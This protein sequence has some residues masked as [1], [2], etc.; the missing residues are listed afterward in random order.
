M[1]R[2]IWLSEL[3]K[4]YIDS[5]MELISAASGPVWEKFSFSPMLKT[6][7]EKWRGKDPELVQLRAK[8]RKI[9]P[10]SSFPPASESKG[11]RE[12]ASWPATSNFGDIR[13]AEIPYIDKTDIIF[14]LTKRRHV[15]LSRPRRFGKTLL[16]NTL[17]HLYLGSKV[18]FEGSY[19]ESQ[20]D[21][22]KKKYPVI[23]LDFSGGSANRFEES[24]AEQ[25]RTVGLEYGL[26]YPE[27]DSTSWEIVF[28]RLVRTLR[29]LNQS[30]GLDP[31]VVILIDEYDKPVVGFL[32]NKDLARQNLEILNSFLA[33]VKYV[34]PVFSIVTGVSRLARASI[35]SGDNARDDISFDP[36]FNAICG[37]TEEEITSNLTPVLGSLKIE[38][39]KE[40]Y[41]G[42]Y[43]G[44]NEGI[45][46]PFS[47]A[48]SCVNKSI[49]SYW[50][51]SGNPAL[52]GQFCG[53][54]EMQNLVKQ[55]IAS[56]RVDFSLSTL[57]TPY[58]ISELEMYWESL[59]RLFV[60]A[61]YLT[62]N[63][64]ANSSEMCSLTI[65]N[66]E[67]KDYGF[68][69]LLITTLMNHSPKICHTLF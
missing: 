23:H 48:K 24:L 20:W 6:D 59:P 56:G 12:F 33:F 58:D 22:K 31:N 7:L 45:Y 38:E 36:E 37:F 44:G 34:D 55:L 41:D 5:L 43:F 51:E 54:T 14:E 50:V 64:D 60:Q 18:L 29:S 40:W 42:Y 10:D 27:N 39:L 19:I 65:P 68:P 69:K 1:K 26:S 46:N 25:L 9:E 11:S 13:S 2:D 53:T 61:G 47:V 8:K 63:P 32:N 52:L 66:K 3:K 35:F 17:K 67:V 15:F 16:L 21:W 49:K 4:N 62:V 57:R 28:E 30:E